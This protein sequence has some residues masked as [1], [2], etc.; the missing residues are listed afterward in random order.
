MIEIHQFGYFM[1]KKILFPLFIFIGLSFSNTTFAFKFV[2]VNNPSLSLGTTDSLDDNLS[3][4]TDAQLALDLGIMKNFK[5]SDLCEVAENTQKYLTTYT[6]DTFAV[7]AGKVFDERI[8]L[9]QVKQTLAFIC[10]TYRADVRANRQSRLYDTEFL[11]QNFTFY[12]W[13]P[14]IET[15][16][17][18][19]LKSNNDVKSRMLNN[20]PHDE[21][22]LTKYYT[23]TLSAST[24]K[25]DKFNQA[26]YSLP[27][28]EQGLS[29][30]QAEKN[31]NLTRFKFTRQQ[32]ID[33]A[34]LNNNL[35]KPLVWITEESLHDVL[36][37]G[38]G[39]LTVNNELRY[40]N[41]HR[42]NGIAYDYSIGK[43]EQARYWYFAEVPSIMGYGKT[44]TSKIAVKPHVTFA[45]NINDLGLGKLFLVSF[46]QEGEQ[47]SRIGVLADQGGAF[48]NNLFQLDLLVD[49]YKGWEDYH[50]ANKTMPDYA[51]AWLLIK[52]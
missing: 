12:R 19:A 30:E 20:I 17:K 41:V 33:G 9:Q 14:D 16:Q 45:G 26:L 43:R 51:R 49:S 25:T 42:V 8:S 37:Q 31:K 47:V 36:L 23:K 40:F 13:M 21:I 7:K 34:L 52:K 24:V 5:A 35:A 39:V 3:D 18:I 48:D 10:E 32:I 44:L 27:F 4:N 50:Q 6:D 28:D 11:K 38:T 15:A 2:E 29:L 1:L 46:M 22:F